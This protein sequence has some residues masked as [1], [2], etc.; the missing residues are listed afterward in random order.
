[1]L[2]TLGHGLDVQRIRLSSISEEP[3][4]YRVNAVAEHRLIHKLV[5]R[6]SL[7]FA[8][9]LAVTRRRTTDQQRL[10]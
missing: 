7:H 6:A 9:C 8:S 10:H 3:D 4:G 5:T 1:M 2:R